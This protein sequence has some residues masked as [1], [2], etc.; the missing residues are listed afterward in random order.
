MSS[1]TQH[2]EAQYKEAQNLVSVAEY[3]L[4]EAQKAAEAEDVELDFATLTAGPPP[5]ALCVRLHAS[6]RYAADALMAC[7]SREFLTPTWY[8][9][10]GEADGTNLA[11][12]ADAEALS[13]SSNGGP[14]PNDTVSGGVHTWHH[15]CIEPLVPELHSM[16]QQARCFAW[17]FPDASDYH[18]K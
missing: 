18:T 3:Q 10:Q 2:Q 9:P 7:V 13:R 6:I 5:N 8:W 12:S 17:T 11:Y 14:P 15:G 1:N 4:K 16:Y